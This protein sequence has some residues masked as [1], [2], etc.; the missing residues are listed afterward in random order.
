MKCSTWQ[1]PNLPPLPPTLLIGWPLNLIP[2]RVQSSW[3]LQFFF[4][5]GT[6]AQSMTS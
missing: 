3:L 1:L 4:K 2:K 6:I 5:V